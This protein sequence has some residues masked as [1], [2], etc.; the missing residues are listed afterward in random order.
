MIGKLFRSAGLRLALLGIA[1]AGIVGVSIPVQAGANDPYPATT[2]EKALEWYRKSLQKKSLDR[3]TKGIITLAMSRDNRAFD[4][5]RGRYMKAE[6]PTDFVRYIVAQVC[7]TYYDAPELHDKWVQWRTSFTK[8]TSAH[9]WYYACSVSVR[10]G[11]LADVEAIAKDEKAIIWLRL[12][13]IEAVADYAKAEEKLNLLIHFAGKGNLPKKGMEKSILL[14]GCASLL[15]GGAADRSMQLYVDAFEALI[16]HLDEEEKSV[17]YRTKLVIGRYL[18]RIYNHDQCY[19]TAAGWRRVHYNQQDSSG[20]KRGATDEV[21]PPTKFMGIE[22]RGKRIAYVLDCS[23]SMLE[24]VKRPPVVKEDPPK[25]DNITGKRDKKE[26][27]KDDKKKEKKKDKDFLSEEDLPWDKIKT[28]W[29]LAREYLKIS[30][31]NLA[32]TN[33][34]HKDMTFTVI[35]YDTIAEPLKCTVGMV[36]ATKGNVEKAMAEI[37]K[38]E[39]VDKRAGGGS[40][41]GG[42]SGGRRNGGGGGG[43]T[44]DRGNTNIHGGMLRAFRSYKGGLLPADNAYCHVNPKCWETGCDTVFLLSDGAPNY[45]DFVDVD[46]YEPD[47]NVVKDVETGEKAPPT[48]NIVYQGPYSWGHFPYLVEDCKRMNRS[49]K[50]EVHTIGT[51]EA[52]MGLLDSISQTGL[53]KSKQVG[54]GG[55]K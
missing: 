24:E 36:D 21:P 1:L 55:Q 34:E 23:T 42:G 5:L 37:D 28:R 39:P 52:D 53:G 51:G 25:E 32:I 22:A 11:H 50:A 12:A 48:E 54:V 17:P 38:I 16:R 3:R 26:E 14:E 19:I 4:E 2:Y 27:K 8:D 46:P 13:A 18:E 35:I 6:K 44:V 10:C 33:K 9:L 29:D 41:S 31:H 45:D 30:L 49:R 20:E 15:M 47:V 43:T 40:G 7:H